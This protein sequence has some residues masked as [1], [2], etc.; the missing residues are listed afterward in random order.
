ML[1]LPPVGPLALLALGL[2]WRRR[3]RRA[4]TALATAGALLLLL[5]MLP[6]VGAVA[7][8]SHQT[9][10]AL[11]AD[12]RPTDERAIVV[13]S[14]DHRG[15]APEDE[16]G[17]TVGPMTLERMRYAARLARSSGLPLLVS[18]GVITQEAEPV[19]RSMATVF[20]R[21]FGLEPRWIEDGSDDTAENARFSAR[22]LSRDGVASVVLVT[23]AWHM[24]RARGAFARAGLGV[25]PAPCG[26]RSAPVLELAAF[27]PSGKAMLETYWG[28]HEWLGRAW[29]ALVDR[30]GE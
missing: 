8:R 7:L 20:T 29:Y 14:G 3:R 2:L 30:A 9:F 18:G 23:H 10:D 5:S 11:P 21:D 4:G 25:T 16:R 27:V 28:L 24:P 19:A 17:V 13:L 12:W 22:L 26:F 1:L 15:D 6:I